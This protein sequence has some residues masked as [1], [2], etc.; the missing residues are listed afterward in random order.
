MLT[1][2]DGRIITKATLVLVI[3]WFR[4]V[5]QATDEVWRQ[6]QLLTS[7]GLGSNVH[8]NGRATWWSSFFMAKQSDFLLK[9]HVQWGLWCPS[10]IF[11]NP[12]MPLTL[13]SWN[14][15]RNGLQ[16]T[17]L[18]SASLILQWSFNHKIEDVMMGEGQWSVW[19]FGTN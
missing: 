1:C 18:G 4:M 10:C 19:K 3:W 12:P 5:A 16:W 17:K 8:E 9:V 14:N 11:K 13:N 6:T 2:G 7:N 15:H